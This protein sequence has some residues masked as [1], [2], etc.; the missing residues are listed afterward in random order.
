MFALVPR[1]RR[2]AAR[3]S[4][5]LAFV[6]PVSAPAVASLPV[7]LVAAREAL[8]QV[9]S[10]RQECE[11]CVPQCAVPD[12]YLRVVQ[13]AYGMFATRVPIPDAARDRRA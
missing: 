2:A 10:G 13:G 6:M 5:S 9:P 11:A 1:R 4:C 3:S 7:A 12:R 8:S